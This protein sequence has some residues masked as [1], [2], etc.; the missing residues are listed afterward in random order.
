M[1]KSLISTSPKETRKLAGSI[2]KE[3]P[4]IRTF[5]LFGDLGSGK[6]TFAKGFGEAL[7]INKAIT[8]PTFTIVGEYEIPQQTNRIRAEKKLFHVDLYR[9]NTVD[10]EM[11]MALNEAFEDEETVVLIEWADKLDADSLPANTLI[12]T[13][14]YQESSRRIITYHKKR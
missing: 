7:G 12:I 9:L 3:F 4:D 5:A 14:A 6:T 10:V 1:N 11:S 13:F 8:S 2:L